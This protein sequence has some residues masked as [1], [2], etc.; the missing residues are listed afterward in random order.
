MIEG[1]RRPISIHRGS[2]A[3]PEVANRAVE[4]SGDNLDSRV[5][6]EL[7]NVFKV[8]AGAAPYVRDLTN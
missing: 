1:L 7:C 8:Q 3:G 2:G 6:G 4:R 5:R